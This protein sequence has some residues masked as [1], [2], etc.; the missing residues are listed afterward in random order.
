VLDARA[1]DRVYGTGI[2]P[3][4]GGRN[5]R[6]PG[7]LN[8]PFGQLLNE[9]GTF[10]SPQDLRAAFE[11]ARVD[12]DRPL[13]TTC[14]SGITASVLLFA[15]H[16]IGKQDVHLYDGSWQEWETDPETPKEQGP[17]KAELA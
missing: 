15:A 17:E 9:D 6:I 7:S 2:D 1:G 3:V 11:A 16:L 12:L 10:K 14:G 8:L 5:G 13:V 4:H